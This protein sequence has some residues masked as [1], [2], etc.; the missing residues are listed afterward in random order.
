MNRLMP[1]VRI[2]Y[3]GASDGISESRGDGG[4]AGTG[5]DPDRLW[6]QVGTLT[7]GA[8]QFETFTGEPLGFHCR[9]HNQGK[10]FFKG[11][12]DNR[13]DRS[14]RNSWNPLI[15]PS[16]RFTDQATGNNPIEPL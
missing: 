2:G 8:Y 3:G 15:Q 10:H 16:H 14:Y 6:V 13:F 1:L 11:V 4:L 9:M 7:D 5:H 12:N